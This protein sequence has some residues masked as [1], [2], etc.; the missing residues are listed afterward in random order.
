[1]NPPMICP[2]CLK[3]ITR[4]KTCLHD[5]GGFY[6]YSYSFV[7]S[8]IIGNNSIIT[9]DVPIPPY[10]RTKIEC[11]SDLSLGVKTLI[12][13]DQ[14]NKRD[15]VQALILLNRFIKLHSFT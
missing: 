12:Y 8:K 6:L 2:F 14:G 11:S 13:E 3:I 10:S 1:M 5:D 9:I 15:P 7:I 4:H